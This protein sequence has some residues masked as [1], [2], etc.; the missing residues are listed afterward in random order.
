MRVT[1][2]TKKYQWDRWLLESQEF[3]HLKSGADFKEYV[4]LIEL[5]E[6][7]KFDCNILV[8]ILSSLF[9]DRY[10][11]NLRLIVYCFIKGQVYHYD[12]E[13]PPPPPEPPSEP[14]VA[15]PSKVVPPKFVEVEKFEPPEGL[16][17]PKNMQVVRYSFRTHFYYFYWLCD[18]SYL[19][20]CQLLSMETRKGQVY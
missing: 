20:L 17:I 12:Y 3:A 15:E 10:F 13:R 5:E 4:I 14:A 2:N 8:N 11:N 9:W 18:L 7:G 6:K 1:Q 19:N 16:E